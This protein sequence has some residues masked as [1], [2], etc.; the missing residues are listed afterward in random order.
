M[1]AEKIK[2]LFLAICLVS[3]IIIF[4]CKKRNTSNSVSETKSDTAKETIQANQNVI[5]SNVMESLVRDEND[6]TVIAFYFHRTIRCD[7]C[8][9]IEAKARRV[10]ENSFANQIADKKLIWVPFNLDE[11]GGEEFGKEFDVSMSTLVLSKTK[12][13]NHT[14]YKKLEKVWQ[15]AHDPEAFNAYVKDEVRQFLNEQLAN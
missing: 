4:G 14:K 3:A 15:L 7:G 8:F 9:E 1:R 13:G 5:D 11:P 10:I 12:N 2:I 6:T